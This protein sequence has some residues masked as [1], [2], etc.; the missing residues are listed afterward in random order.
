[1]RV[2]L[3]Y[4]RTGLE[5]NL[6]DERVFGPLAIRNV[7]PLADPQVALTEAVSSLTLTPTIVSFPRRK[8]RGGLPITVTRTVPVSPFSSEPS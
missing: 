2:T 3:D 1:M 4:G 6:P 8:G 7:E 5:V